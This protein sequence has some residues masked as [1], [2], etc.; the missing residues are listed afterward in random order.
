MPWS[1]YWLLL[2]PDS[3]T[4]A[5]GCPKRVVVFR[6]GLRK[7]RPLSTTGRRALRLN[8]RNGL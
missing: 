3:T 2:G 4:L 7:A 1:P 5:A 8:L 6:T